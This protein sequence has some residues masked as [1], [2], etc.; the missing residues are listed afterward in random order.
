[1]RGTVMRTIVAAVADVAVACGAARDSV[2]PLIGT[3]ADER[4]PIER[5]YEVWEVAVRA[6]R[7]TSLP[8]RVGARAGFDRYGALG[9]ALYV[10]GDNETA[11]RRLCR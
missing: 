3:S 5:L 6:T 8:I 2:D 10:S 7:C 9:I 4:L 1:M 11:L